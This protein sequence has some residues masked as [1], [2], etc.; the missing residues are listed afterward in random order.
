MQKLAL[1]YIVLLP[2][3]MAALYRIHTGQIEPDWSITI[4]LYLVVLLMVVSTWYEFKENYPKRYE[5]KFCCTDEKQLL[6]SNGMRRTVKVKTYRFL[7]MAIDAGNVWCNV[8]RRPYVFEYSLFDH[9]KYIFISDNGN[10]Y[11][12][13]VLS[14]RTRYITRM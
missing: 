6:N 12:D 7:W 2:F 11:V 14:F 10:L 3:V 8:T 9:T 13:G 5:V 4:L 1:F